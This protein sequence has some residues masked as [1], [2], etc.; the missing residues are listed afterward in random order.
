MPDHAPHRLWSTLSVRR[1]GKPTIW[2]GMGSYGLHLA[3]LAEA[4]GFDL[5]NS[6]VRQIIVAAEPL[7]PAKRQKLERAFGAKVSDQFGM[8]EGALISVQSPQ[9]DG[10]HVWSDLFLCEVIDEATGQPVPEG[11]VGSLVMT[12]LW[13]NNVTPFLRWNSGDLV[14]VQSEGHGAGPWSL[15]PV[16]HHARRTVGFFK[17]RGVNINHNELE[18]LMFYNAS[19][20]DFKAEVYN[21]DAGL[22]VL[23]L[24]VEPKRGLDRDTVGRGIAE[25][26][27][28]TFEVMPEI[29]FLEPGTLGKEFEASIKAARFVDKRG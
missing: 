7:S 28:K 17:V 1:V 5:A 19:V 12:P 25:G 20:Q 13:N 9:H 27:R 21:S 11:D 26:V 15:F 10:L 8:T 2:A 24:L 4:H 16:M 3:N 29:A 18:D 6:S 22:D 14:S 23:R